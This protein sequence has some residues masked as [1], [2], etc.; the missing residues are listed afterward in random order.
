M[1]VNNNIQFIESISYNK[2]I[3]NIYLDDA[4]QSYIL[5]YLNDKGELVETG[6]GSY[7]NNYMWCIEELFGDPLINCPHYNTIKVKNKN[8]NYKNKFGFCHKCWFEDMNWHMRQNLIKSH[9][10]DRRLNINPNYRE[11][12]EQILQAYKE[13]GEYQE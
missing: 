6:L 8:C 5:E 1:K 11:L 7:N 12:F 13:G 3:I 2:K 10:I 4:G 9:F